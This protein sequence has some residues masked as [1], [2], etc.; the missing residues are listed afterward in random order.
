MSVLYA[1]LARAE[2]PKLRTGLLAVFDKKYLPSLDR[3]VI[4]VGYEPGP[5]TLFYGLLPR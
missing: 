4:L 2:F 3:S 1:I 5:G